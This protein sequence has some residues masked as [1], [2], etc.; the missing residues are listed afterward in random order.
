MK[1]LKFLIIALITTISVNGQENIKQYSTRLNVKQLSLTKWNTKDGV[2]YKKVPGANLGVT[3]F[4]IVD[5][6]RSAFL[7]NSSH[8]VVVVNLKNGLPIKRFS[9]EFA[10]RDFV[11]D[12]KH[13]YVLFENSVI[14][15]NESGRKINQYFFP[16]KYM[17]VERITRNC[18]STFL[19][20]PSGNSLKIESGG[21]SI[22]PIESEGWI[23]A[24]GDYI[25]PTLSEGNE[26]YINMV[27]ADGKKFTKKIVAPK[28]VAGVFVV[29]STSNRIALDVQMYI[30]ENPI[31]V[32]REIVLV[33]MKNSGIG[34]V[35]ASQKIPDYYYVLSNKELDINKN[36]EV[37]SM[38]T[39]EQGIM[40]FSLN[41]TNSKRAQGYPTFLKTGKYHFN[42]DLLKI[43]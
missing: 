11:Y 41:E 5:N 32:E 16:N 35:I 43:K 27:S 9:V 39:S 7:A 17:G 20:L 38:T 21:K 1:K 34:N 31:E 18:S 42:N 2:E 23:T 25:K 36:G 3:S 12:S 13:F 22:E 26:Y 30:S 28:K 29:G 14:A 15:Y 8:E 19:L 24:N 4:C 40:L 10:P 33:E 37:Y 6:D